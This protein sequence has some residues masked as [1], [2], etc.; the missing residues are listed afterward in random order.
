M[1]KKKNQNITFK[2]FYCN[3]LY[4]PTMYGTWPKENPKR[5]LMHYGSSHDLEVHNFGHLKK[6][7]YC[8]KCLDKRID[9]GL[10]KLLGYY[11]IWSGEIVAKTEKEY[12]NCT[13]KEF[14]E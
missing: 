9:V 3:T 10:S 14:K 2:C 6:G 7:N 5:L 1:K 4:D 13:N 8:Y 11:D 12:V